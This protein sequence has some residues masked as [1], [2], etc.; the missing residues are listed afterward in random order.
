MINRRIKGALGEL[1][2]VDF[3]RSK[4]YKILEQNYRTINGEIDIIA[5][6]NKCYCFIEVK[7]RST[8]KYGYGQESVDQRK[9]NTIARVA[10]HYLQKNNLHDV[11]VRF[12]VVSVSDENGHFT[13]DI[14]ENAFE[15]KISH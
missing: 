2:V 14:F 7:T 9:Q 13:F 8:L 1:A 11:N 6:K 3:L 12:D 10:S 15:S 4:K 5:L